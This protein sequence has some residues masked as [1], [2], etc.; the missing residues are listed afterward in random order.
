ECNMNTCPTG[1]ATQDQSLVDG[2]V[3]DDKKVRVANFH[4][5]TVESFVE[6]MGASGIAQPTL[7]NRHQI[8]RRV[9]MNQVLT[10]EEIYP[11]VPL[12][13]MLGTE[14]PERYKM[15]YVSASAEKF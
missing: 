10:L 15:S 5:N 7:L 4:K 1:V 14:I 2:L 3:V 8:N 11:S 12:G 13:A 9:F 6:L